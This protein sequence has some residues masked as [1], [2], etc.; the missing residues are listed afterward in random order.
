MEPLEISLLLLH[1]V[2]HAVEQL[3]VA[4]DLPRVGEFLVE[5]RLPMI[6]LNVDILCGH[7]ADHVLHRLGGHWLTHLVSLHDWRL[8]LAAVRIEPRNGRLGGVACQWR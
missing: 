1:V 5:N 6:Y 4:L 7:V 2:M 8:L 3:L